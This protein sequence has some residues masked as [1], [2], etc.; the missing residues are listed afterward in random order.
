MMS[1]DPYILASGFAKIVL[2]K[3]ATDIE[4]TTAAEYPLKRS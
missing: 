3:S 4:V 1:F 2:L